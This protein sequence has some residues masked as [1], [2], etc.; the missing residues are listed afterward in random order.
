MNTGATAAVELRSR[1]RDREEDASEEQAVI[2]PEDETERDTKQEDDDA[3]PAVTNSAD[4]AGITAKPPLK[5][6]PRRMLSPEEKTFVCGIDG[7]RKAYGS[8]SS[9]CAHKRTHHPGW[10]WKKAHAVDQKKGSSLVDFSIASRLDQNE[11]ANPSN[12]SDGEEE[13]PTAEYGYSLLDRIIKHAPVGYLAQQIPGRL[14][15]L[16]STAAGGLLAND[17]KVD[18]IYRE[19]AL[20][21]AMVWLDL[22]LQDAQGRLTALLQSRERIQRARIEEENICMLSRKST[23]DS[24]GGKAEKAAASISIMFANMEYSLEMEIKRLE[25]WANSVQR[26]MKWLSNKNKTIKS[27]AEKI[28]ANPQ[29]SRKLIDDRN[30]VLAIAA[31]AARTLATAADVT[32]PQNHGPNALPTHMQ[33]V[34]SMAGSGAQSHLQSAA[35]LQAKENLQ[36][37]ANSLFKQSLE[38]P[39]P[40]P[41]WKEEVENRKSGA[42][43]PEIKSTPNES[44][45]NAIQ[46]TAAPKPPL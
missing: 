36:T 46:N 27:A 25:S 37:V 22:L 42:I 18:D 17:P 5:R 21:P 7:C 30:D 3:S 14:A 12:L 33:L 45:L 35:A 13:R 20:S 9:L 28:S 19:P 32:W 4:A 24:T 6:R 11:A 1:K 29:E 26:M 43:K 40:N 31:V 38:H 10:K 44:L 23:V 2:D 16:A 34:S 8:A 39:K 41:R 15:S